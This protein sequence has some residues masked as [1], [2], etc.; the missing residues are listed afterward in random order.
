M[1]LITSTWILVGEK[2][3]IR[4]S[5]SADMR[6]LPARKSESGH[7]NK[8]LNGVSFIPYQVNKGKQTYYLHTHT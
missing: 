2:A 7:D 3:K 6:S 5:M 1:K 4:Q 8:N